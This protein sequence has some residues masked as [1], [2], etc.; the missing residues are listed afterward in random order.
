MATKPASTPDTGSLLI[1]LVDGT[2]RPLP[3]NIQWTATLFDGR[4]PSERRKFNINGSGP[5]ELIKDLPF[6]DN[7]FDN[8][9]VIVSAG[10]FEGAAWKPVT[11]SPSRVA[12][13]DLMLLPEGGHFNFAGAGWQQ[14]RGLRS[15]LFEILANGSKNSRDA[16]TRYEKIMEGNAG[17]VL[18][19]LLNITTAIV[20]INLPNGKTPLDYYWQLIWDDPVF[21][22]AQD[23]FYAYVDKALIDQVAQAA[24]LGAFAPERDP[25]IFHS[26]ATR[27]YKQT[28][29]DVT[30]VQ[31]TFHEGNQRSIPTTGVGTMDCV[32]V[33]SDIDYF[34]DPL[35]H[36]FLEVVPN[37]AT[38]GLTD[39]KVVYV[40]RW[41]A[42]R[43]AGIPDFDPLYT[44]Q[45]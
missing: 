25:K 40:L 20:Q 34:R 2:R 27:S 12:Q 29:F 9:T 15:K 19:A 41:M 6:F 22:M 35:A 14:L 1:N 21:P 23:R 32:V 33:E 37:K 24:K 45:A 5:V 26:G 28:Q 3:N 11:I 7:F 42:G 36:F 16:E 8:Y 43:Q 31:L 44:I 38:R 4:A 39:P 18:A 10:D 30:N 17:V 13:V